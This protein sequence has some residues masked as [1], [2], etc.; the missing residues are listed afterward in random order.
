MTGALEVVQEELD[1]V[2]PY[3]MHV[4]IIVHLS[5]AFTKTKA[6][7]GFFKVS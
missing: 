5:Y 2:Q 6:L 4:C 1:A 3:S 7:L